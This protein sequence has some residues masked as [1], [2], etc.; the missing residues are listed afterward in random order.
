MRDRGCDRRSRP[1]CRRCWAPIVVICGLVI[2]RRHGGYDGRA[3]GENDV[4]SFAAFEELLEHDPVSGGAELPF[5]HDHLNGLARLLA[6]LRHDHTFAGGEAVR[7]DDDRVTDFSGVQPRERLLRLEW[8]VQSAV[9]IAWRA[10]NSLA[11]TL[12]DSSRAASRPGPRAAIPARAAVGRPSA[13]GASGPMTTRSTRSRRTSSSRAAWS[14]GDTGT[15]RASLR[16]RRCPERT[17][18]SR[19]RAL[20]RS[21]QTS[22]CSRPPDRSPEFA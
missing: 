4:R 3:V 13:R 8:I 6:R 10:M 12:L 18:L 20:C 21:F 1:P 7:F 9:G 5:D 2:L 19:T 11:N 16:F 17:Q 14:E 15:Q 22:A